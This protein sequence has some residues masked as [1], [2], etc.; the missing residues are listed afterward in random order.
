MKEIL[1]KMAS[2]KNVV[3]S[4][5]TNFYEQMPAEF[6]KK[7]HSPGFNKHN[8]KI[9][10]RMGIFG[11]PGSMK[12]NTFLQLLRLMKETFNKIVI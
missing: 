12:T 7:Y 3:K 10:F 2:K 8:I 4:D 5:M 9:P 1:E 6:I 11:P